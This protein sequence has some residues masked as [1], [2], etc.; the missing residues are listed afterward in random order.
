MSGLSKIK[1][2]LPLLSC[3]REAEG[4]AE[5]E[6]EGEAEDGWRKEPELKWK[7]DGETE[8]RWLLGGEEMTRRERGREG[9]REGEGI[10]GYGNQ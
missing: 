3:R 8:S 1:S 2:R 10:T 7:K 9:E 4:E 5:A 6:A